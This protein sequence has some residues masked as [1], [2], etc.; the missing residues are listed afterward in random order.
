VKKGLRGR[1]GTYMP[2][3]LEK[4]ALAELEH[5]PRNHRMRAAPPA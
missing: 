5:D 4:L 3:L 1:F 2:P